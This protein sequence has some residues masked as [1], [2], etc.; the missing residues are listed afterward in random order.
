VIFPVLE[1]IPIFRL[2]ALRSSPP[3]FLKKKG[4]KIPDVPSSFERY[5]STTPRASL[6]LFLALG[7]LSLDARMAAKLLL[8]DRGRRYGLEARR[9]RRGWLKFGVSKNR[10]LSMVSGL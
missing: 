5:T 4:G 10:D 8:S 2:L 7:Y 9:A 3:I 1:S 6:S